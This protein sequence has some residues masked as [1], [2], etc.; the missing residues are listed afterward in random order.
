M[1]YIQRLVE[2]HAA[3]H[4]A[5]LLT[6]IG[7]DREE[8]PG[9]HLL[10]APDGT[11]VSDFGD[12]ALAAK[13]IPLG[14]AAIRSGVAGIVQAEE[15]R[16]YVEPFLP[17][18]ALV[19]VGAGHV[20][21]PLALFG[22]MLG[23]EV[24]VI[25]DRVAYANRERFPTAGRIICDG[26]VSALEALDVGSRHHVVLV[27]RGH[28][29]DLDCLRV[30]AGKPAA[31]IGMIGS[32]NRI[33]TV[34]R[35]LAEEHGID[36]RGLA[37]IHAPIG[38]DIG[39]RAPA[40]IG[41]AVAAEILKVRSGGTGESLSRLGRDAVHR[42]GAHTGDIEPFRLLLAV[43]G[44]AALATVVHTRGHCPREVG[45]RMLVRRDGSASGTIGGGC[46]ESAVRLR[47]LAVMDERRP[48]LHTVDLLDDPALADG[49]VC[50]GKMSVWIEPVC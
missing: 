26:F 23:F 3:G 32:R 34:F 43:P 41:L 22:Q 16:V 9:R 18:P 12:D 36:A 5:A 49:A 39:A 25:D 30:L 50:G 37:H 13:L 31:Y 45:A 24:I 21:Q 17:P 19:V 27:T 2:T 48:V 44:P 46:G 11:S 1:K 4:P 8:M 14:T 35:L 29:H 40:E 47:A 20:A 10:V 42:G 7:A 6:I 15:M 28:R 38:L 33:E